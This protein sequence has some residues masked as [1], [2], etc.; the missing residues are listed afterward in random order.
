MAAYKIFSTNFYGAGPL[1]GCTGVK[2]Y[3][4]D[5]GTVE[6]TPVEVGI[7][8]NGFVNTTYPVSDLI[9]GTGLY[10]T[11]TNKRFMARFSSAVE[12]RAIRFLGMSAAP[13]VTISYANDTNPANYEG[14]VLGSW[15]TLGRP[16]V[17]GTGNVYYLQGG[18]PTATVNFTVPLLPKTGR[19][20]K[21]RP[22]DLVTGES[23]S[24]TGGIPTAPCTIQWYGWEYS[25]A[26]WY[27]I[28]GA[29]AADMPSTGEVV[30]RDVNVRFFT[31]MN[32]NKP[33]G[34]V[35]NQ[36][37][38]AVTIPAVGGSL[39]TCGEKIWSVSEFMLE[40]AMPT[41]DYGIVGV[42]VPITAD[43]NNCAT[44][45]MYAGGSGSYTFAWTATG[46][47]PS[48]GTGA[49]FNPVWST[50][51]NKTVVLSI[52]SGTQTCSFSGTVSIAA[53]AI[54]ATITATPT[55]GGI[56]QSF[57]FSIS[58]VSGGEIPGTYSYA[59]SGP[60]GLTGSGA[61]VSKVFSSSGTKTVQCIITSGA[62]TLTKT[63]NVTVTDPPITGTITATPNPVI[64]GSPV[65]LSISPLG[66]NGSYTY[67]W[68]GAETLTG[69]TSSVSKTYATIGTKSV[70][71]NV[72]S[73][74]V[75]TAFTT[76]VTVENAPALVVEVTASPITQLINTNVVFTAVVSGGVGGYT[77]SWAGTDGLTA[78]TTSATFQWSTVGTKTVSLTVTSGTQN[79][80][81]DITV[82]IVNTMPTNIGRLC[83]IS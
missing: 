51:G 46:A 34:P 69:T 50:P 35:G 30:G 28:P 44:G 58:G 43:P 52:T 77:Y 33:I 59:W 20:L 48:T 31:G 18:N 80:T 39:I 42:A 7:D 71:C 45:F 16:T 70:T 3:S 38:L 32:A 40:C 55:S 23:V 37:K 13:I 14:N 27:P 62:S 5:L 82:L 24:I 41:V 11:L 10:A 49:S 73:N 15:N 79:A 54:T 72:T 36:F 68:S 26:A 2:F 47:T 1:A 83:F 75:T 12:L 60:D 66:G 17:G 81:D 78:T 65:T 6:I 61:S 21:S 4:D 22:C 29:S 19:V 9:S 57:V 74:G 53:P 76:T 56:D 67:S 64:L 8:V 25:S 63:V